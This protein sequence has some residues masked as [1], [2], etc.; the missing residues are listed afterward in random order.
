MCKPFPRTLNSFFLTPPYGYEEIYI[1]GFGFFGRIQKRQNVAR[2]PIPTCTVMSSTQ[3]KKQPSH[4]FR[5]IEDC[6]PWQFR[7]RKP[8][9]TVGNCVHSWEKSVF[10]PPHQGKKRRRWNLQ[11]SNGKFING[12]YVKGIIKHIALHMMRLI[13]SITSSC[14]KWW[15]I[16][17]WEPGRNDMMP[18]VH[19][20]MGNEYGAP[21]H[22][23]KPFRNVR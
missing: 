23:F 4:Q 21:Q 20:T 7:I 9:F 2:Q 3:R 11:F 17:N 15:W 19:Y 6:L 13:R 14:Y 1:Y 5:A 18:P 22:S 16:T 10:F 12:K 8:I